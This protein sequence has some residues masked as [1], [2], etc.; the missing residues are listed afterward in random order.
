MNLLRLA[1]NPKAQIIFIASCGGL[2]YYNN[3]HT[4]DRSLISN[5]RQL[6][7]AK[8]DNNYSTIIDTYNKDIYGQNV[9]REKWNADRQFK[10]NEKPQD[11]NTMTQT[12]ASDRNKPKYAINV[13]VKDTKKNI[14][15]KQS[16]NVS[17]KEID[18]TMHCIKRSQM[19]SDFLRDCVQNNFG[20]DWDASIND[21]PEKSKSEC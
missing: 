6:S 2:W 1:R 14:K 8:Q 4:N 16:Q 12:V 15:T 10:L 5:Y 9:E 11:S 21:K 17:Q 19:N 20:K 13:K 18:L 7:V 3:M